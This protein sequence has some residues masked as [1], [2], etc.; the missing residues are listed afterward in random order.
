MKIKRLL[1]KG[2]NN[3]P[4]VGVPRSINGTP[5]VF[6]MTPSEQKE[7]TLPMGIGMEF[8]MAIFPNVTVE[9]K[10]WLF[11]ND[12]YGTIKEPSR[13]SN[14][15][16]TLNLDGK[17]F[18]LEQRTIL[19]KI[20][21]PNTTPLMYRNMIDDKTIN[22]GKGGPEAQFSPISKG[23][24]PIF[25]TEVSRFLYYMKKMGCVFKLPDASN[26]MHISKEMLGDTELEVENTL[27][28]FMWLLYGL[29]DFLPEFSSRVGVGIQIADIHNYLG[30]PFQEYNEK[31]LLQR[32]MLQKSEALSLLRDTKKWS[33]K[34]QS[35]LD[36][37]WKG[38]MNM[39]FL[40]EH[41]TLEFRW[42]G[43]TENPDVVVAQMEWMFAAIEYSKLNGVLSTSDRHTILSSFCEYINDYKTEYPH[44]FNR[45]LDIKASKDFMEGNKIPTPDYLS[46]YNLQAL[47]EFNYEYLGVIDPKDAEIAE[48]VKKKETLA[49]IIRSVTLDISKKEEKEAEKLPPPGHYKSVLTN[50]VYPYKEYA[51]KFAIYYD[52]N[53]KKNKM[54]FFPAEENSLIEE[55][56]EK[57]EIDTE[58]LAGYS[59]TYD[60]HFIDEDDEEWGTP[61][62][63][64]N[65]EVKSKFIPKER[66]RM[67]DY[68]VNL[69]INGDDLSGASYII[70]EKP[71]Y[72][73]FLSTLSVVHPIRKRELDSILEK[74]EDDCY[75]ESLDDEF[76]TTY[77]TEGAEEISDSLESMLLTELEKNT[78]DSVLKDKTS[79]P[80]Y[81]EILGRDREEFFK[82]IEKQ[83]EEALTNLS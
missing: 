25:K 78:Y 21:G 47:L 5:I 60:A 52:A 68:N 11:D 76:V 35:N 48:T 61:D 19:E 28:N 1:E 44:L 72:H 56:I 34:A 67:Y 23:S 57:G 32:F 26:H 4:L 58:N 45:M 82:F 15:P 54:G 3:F 37:R 50:K 14:T 46:E 31:A 43:A 49:S 70:Y 20:I 29:R 38:F 41:D 62:Y 40:N 55:L 2:L 65:F 18:A 79:H 59:L 83:N 8:E 42:F 75:D 6:Y 27:T 51:T 30:D 64:E 81:L 80:A 13:F 10:E 39:T 36:E 66:C 9:H 77:A 33:E 71:E 7:G 12:I 16:I 74:I 17:R 73:Q 24:L 53:L 22:D 63:Y 69:I